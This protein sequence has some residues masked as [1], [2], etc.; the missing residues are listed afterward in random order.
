MAAD[1]TVRADLPGVA[2]AV[3]VMILGFLGETRLNALVVV[4]ENGA[5]VAAAV[6]HQNRGLH[7]DLW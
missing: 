1:A 3:A 4:W 6:S 2:V 7:H 5:V